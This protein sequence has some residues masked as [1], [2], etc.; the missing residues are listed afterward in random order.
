MQQDNK[1][2]LLCS[3]GSNMVLSTH[4][5]KV[6]TAKKV[7]K[8]ERRETLQ[9]EAQQTERASEQAAHRL[10]GMRS[11][12]ESA[13]KD[14]SRQKSAPAPKMESLDTYV[15]LPSAV[16]HAKDANAVESYIWHCICAKYPFF[17]QASLEAVRLKQLPKLS[18]PMEIVR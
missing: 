3:Y 7:Q 6:R 10:A 2:C 13:H 8:R 12:G 17:P 11:R 14:R 4:V 5:Q 1:C 15:S 16:H 18:F 9:R